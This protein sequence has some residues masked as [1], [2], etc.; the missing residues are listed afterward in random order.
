MTIV[1]PD[2]TIGPA[3]PAPAGVTVAEGRPVVVEVNG[4]AGKTV[5]ALSG[6]ATLTPV[7]AYGN[8]TGAA[9]PVSATPAVALPT[10]GRVLIEHVGALGESSPLQFA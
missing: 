10:N 3:F 9:T 6:A 4:L 1:A 7:D 8:R 5:R 2:I